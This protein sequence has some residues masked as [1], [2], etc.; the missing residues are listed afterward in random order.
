MFDA[1]TVNQPAIEPENDG[2]WTREQA[3][4]HM[5]EFLASLATAPLI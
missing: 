2:F 5:R 4:A 3:E 1:N